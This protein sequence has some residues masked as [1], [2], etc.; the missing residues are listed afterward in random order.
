M[1]S[2]REQ[3]WWA[4][5]LAKNP[6]MAAVVVMTLVRTCLA[7]FAHNGGYLTLL[8]HGGAVVSMTSSL[9]H[10]KGAKSRCCSVVWHSRFG[11]GD[12]SLV[13]PATGRLRRR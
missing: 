4:Y 6:V 8:G 2:L 3:G 12:F 9:H 5:G 13:E 10:G 1:D 11:R 7:L